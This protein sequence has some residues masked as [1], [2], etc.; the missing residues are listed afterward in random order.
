MGL[1]F[2]V[3]HIVA[4]GFQKIN[5]ALPPI[6]ALDYGFETFAFPFTTFQNFLKIP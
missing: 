5:P 3:D 1:A 4:R 6:Q 2:E